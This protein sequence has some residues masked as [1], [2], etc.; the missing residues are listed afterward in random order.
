MVLIVAV[1]VLATRIS[2][3][4]SLAANADPPP[5]AP[6]TVQ[7]E[8]RTLVEVVTVRGDVVVSGLHTLPPMVNGDDLVFTEAPMLGTELGQT[9]SIFE[10]SGRPVFVFQGEF[11]AYRDL[12]LGD[13]G[14]DVEALGR[15][16]VDAG[17]LASPLSEVFDEAMSAAVVTMYEKAGYEPLNGLT[18]PGTVLLR[19]EFL[20]VPHLPARLVQVA[21]LSGDLEEVSG[22]A[23][24]SYG[25]AWGKAE[26]RVSQGGARIPTLDDLTAASATLPDGSEAALRVVEDDGLLVL[27]ATEGARLESFLGSSVAIRLTRSSKIPLM[28]VPRV[29]VVTNVE[30]DQ[31]VLRA[32]N[33]ELEELTVEVLFQTAGEI[34]VSSDQLVPGDRIVVGG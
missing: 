21:S 13:K 27:A 33:G 10:V 24:E 5:L 15:A 7:V 3:P 1:W 8:S 17:L 16:L 23:D 28:V 2:T 20:F 32:D 34:G 22:A 26:I 29:A 4:E 12:T 6:V 31:V 25:L 30:G 19:R 14:P 9:E 18:G 11:I